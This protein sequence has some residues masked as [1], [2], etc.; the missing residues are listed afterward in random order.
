MLNG[1]ITLRRPRVRDL[2]ERFESRILPLFKRRTQAVGDLLPEL[3]L[4][5]LSSGDFEPA[6]RGLLGAG[7]PLSARFMLRL[8]ARFEVEHEAWQKQELSQLELVYAW[9]GGLHVK[10]GIED[11]KAALLVIVGALSSGEQVL[12]AGA[13]GQWE[14]RESW[15]KVLRDLK[16]RGL[17]RPL[18]TVADGHLGLWAALGELHPGGEE[19]RCWNHKLVNVFDDLP[20]KQQPQ[21]VELLKAIA[22]A[23]REPRQQTIKPEHPAA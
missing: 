1:T 19:Q 9:A 21:A 14:S 7:A 8:K 11:R 17:K 16:T 15:L 5:G 6:R 4:H 12:P 13:S 10:A 22:G 2:A 18:L 3:Y 20:K 23:K